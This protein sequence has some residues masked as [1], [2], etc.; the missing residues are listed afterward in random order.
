MQHSEYF[1]MV[2]MIHKRS[3]HESTQTNPQQIQ[4]QIG[5]TIKISTHKNSK[6]INIKLAGCLPS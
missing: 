1:S 6:L 5:I 4:L 3:I 2:T